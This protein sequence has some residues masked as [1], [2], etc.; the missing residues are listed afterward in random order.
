MA[1]ALGWHSRDEL[2]GFRHIRRFDPVLYLG[3]VVA[4]FLIARSHM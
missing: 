3:L 1:G 2:Q 4:L